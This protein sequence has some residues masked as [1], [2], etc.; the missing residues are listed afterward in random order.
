MVPNVGAQGPGQSGTE[1]QNVM[2]WPGSLERNSWTVFVVP[3]WVL[4]S[5]L[6][7]QKRI[8]FIPD[9]DIS[10]SR[11]ALWISAKEDQPATETKL[12]WHRRPTVLKTAVRRYLFRN[13]RGPSRAV[14]L[15]SIFITQDRFEP[16]RDTPKMVSTKSN[17]QTIAKP[18]LPLTPRGGLSTFMDSD[19]ARRRNSVTQLTNG[20]D[21]KRDAKAGFAV[22]ILLAIGLRKQSQNPNQDG[23]P[24]HQAHQTCANLG[25]DKVRW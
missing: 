4:R 18:D 6:F 2:R 12:V 14:P 22:V 16:E 5:A 9:R 19:A 11:V 8:D 1:I 10:V 25:D 24:N 13:G 3:I 20:M 17:A 15:L 23:A 7:T 21:W